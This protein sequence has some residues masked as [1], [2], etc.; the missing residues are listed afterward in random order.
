MER[1]PL[2]EL[3]FIVCSLTELIKPPREETTAHFSRGP[4][5]DLWESLNRR[6]GNHPHDRSGYSVMSL[7]HPLAKLQLGTSTGTTNGPVCVYSWV[8]NDL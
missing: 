7:S 4:L 8:L 6:L 3:A 2:S 5:K 1:E